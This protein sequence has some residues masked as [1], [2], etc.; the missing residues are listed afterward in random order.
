MDVQ[1]MIHE[2]ERI[3]GLEVCAQRI[4]WLPPVDDP[5]F[6]LDQGRISPRKRIQRSRPPARLPLQMID[7]M[8]SFRRR[9][10]A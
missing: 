5:A 7:Q 1:R 2:N 10:L 4:P 3:G 6:L 8:R 9:R